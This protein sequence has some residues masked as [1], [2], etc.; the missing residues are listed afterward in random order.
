MSLKAMTATNHAFAM[1]VMLELGDD[2]NA[3]HVFNADA[4]TEFPI[5][6]HDLQKKVVTFL[7]PHSQT[8]YTLHY[9]DK[10]KFRLF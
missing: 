10:K 5:V 9:C 4:D 3:V 8:T 1:E 6:Q 2:G 7:H